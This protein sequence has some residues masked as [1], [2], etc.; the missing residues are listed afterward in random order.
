MRR[1]LGWGGPFTGTRILFQLYLN[2]DSLIVAKLLGQTRLGYYSYALRLAR[3]LGERIFSIVNRASLPSFASLKNDKGSLI[4]HWFTLTQLLALIGFPAMLALALNAR[5]F[6]AVVLGEKWLPAVVPLQL[7][8]ISEA[9][10]S[11]Q[12]VLPPLL[13]SQGR[14]DLPLRYTA[15][16]LTALPLSFAAACLIGDLRGVALVWSRSIRF[17]CS[18]C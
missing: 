14:P 11:I 15:I 6:V 2:S 13:S 1:V 17:W 8:C 16:S 4:H 3:F 12:T 10:R 9:V 7:L 5:D 18:T